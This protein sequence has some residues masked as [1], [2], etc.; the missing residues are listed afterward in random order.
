M[1]QI[2][3]IS[4]VLI[5]FISLVFISVHSASAASFD[6]LL[7][8]ATALEKS[9]DRAGAIEKYEE[10]IKENPESFSAEVRLA[11][12]LKKAKR[13]DEA[14]PHFR[15][16]VKLSSGRAAR[17][18]KTELATV[19]SWRDNK[20][21]ALDLYIEVLGDDPKNTEARMGLARVYSWTGR[22]VEA[23]QEYGTILKRRPKSTEAR[24]GMARVSSWQGDYD[25]AIETYRGILKGDPDNTEA[26]VGLINVLRWKGEV[27]EGLVEARK[28]LAE[29][30]DNPE[31]QR[32]ERALRKA[33]GP[34]VQFTRSDGV[35][36]D[37]NRLVRHKLSGYFSIWDGQLLRLA[38]TNYHAT[39]PFSQEAD[40][41]VFTAK[42][43]FEL[44]RDLKLT[45][46][47]S[48][49][50]LEAR[51]GD[52]TRLLPAISAKWR[53]SKPLTLSSSYSQSV[54]LDT[55]QLIKNAIKLDSY[56]VSGSYDYSI[57]TV[58]SGLRYGKYPDGNSSMRFNVKVSRGIIDEA[59]RTLTG[60]VRIDYVN[61]DK[62]LN[63]G[64]YDPQDYLALTA[65][66]TLK[67]DY[68]AERLFYEAVGGAGM[69]TKKGSNTDLKMSLKGKLTWQFNRNLSAWAAYKW[70]RSE[71]ES[72]TG[73]SYNAYEIGLG[74]LF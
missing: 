40:A 29:A 50:S 32:I 8:E 38:Y 54:L 43:T 58:S 16:A 14:I 31:A 20:D 52:V 11:R 6:A 27:S 18:V 13:V 57:Y 65:R 47:L 24:M 60:G 35:D 59:H 34:Y 10:A 41:N 68:Y 3:H 42:S 45:P 33:K 73:Y 67:G 37:D 61:F 74:Y 12:L 23:R 55:A 25:F 66:A 15:S 17:G 39:A 4:F 63:N 9:G 19:L 30:P 28:F 1:I 48:I 71:L 44:S 56:S 21:E 22:Y 46:R 53:Y 70:S 69:Q 51:G 72:A 49:A 26:R 5:I 62:D 7:D 64:Y 36:S 2:R